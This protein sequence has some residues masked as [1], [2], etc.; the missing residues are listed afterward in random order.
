[1]QVKLLTVK[2]DKDMT[3]KQKENENNEDEQPNVALSLK[4]F[5]LHQ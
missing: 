3:T 5:Y 2:N 4:Q 1:M